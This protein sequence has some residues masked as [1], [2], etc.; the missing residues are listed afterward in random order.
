MIGDVAQIITIASYGN[1]FLNNGLEKLDCRNHSSFCSIGDP[2][3]KNGFDDHAKR[4][5]TNKWYEYIKKQGCTQIRIFYNVV[6]PKKDGV[7]IN[8]SINWVVEAVFNGYS[9]YWTYHLRYGSGG[10]WAKIEKS[11]SHQ[12]IISKQ[13]DLVFRKDDLDEKLERLI[14]FSSQ[15]AWGNWAKNFRDMK[16]ILY[17]DSPTLPDFHKDLIVAKNY[18]LLARQVLYSAVSSWCFT[19]MGSWSDNG[20]FPEITRDLFFSVCDAYVASVNSY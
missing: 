1:E 10:W 8:E 15:L 16:N 2:V 18:S 20:D 11:E 17:S 4:L 3:Y 19:G 14:E 12:S 5:D 7:L 6:D 9:D 13:D